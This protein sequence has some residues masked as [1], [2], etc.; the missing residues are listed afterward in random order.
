ME[1]TVAWIKPRIKSMIWNIRKQTTRRKRIQKKSEDG[2]SSLWD[3]F[4][5][6]NIHIGVPEEEEKEQE[7]ENLFEEIVKENFPNLV[8]ELDIQVQE[9]KRAPN[10]M[11]T[12]KTT[13]KHIIIN[14]PKVKQRIL[15]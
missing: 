7:I 4:Q 8:K 12:R 2:T 9:A 14:M 1:T 5:S 11:N 13:I 15:N 6:S 3:N 10:K